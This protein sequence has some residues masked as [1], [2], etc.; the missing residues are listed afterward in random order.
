MYLA[1]RSKKTFPTY[2]QAF[3][4][5]WCHGIEIGKMVFWWTDMEFA[6]HLILLN[7]CNATENMFKQAS[8]VVSLLKEA[9]EL[10]SL[11]GSKVV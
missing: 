8:A 6:G 9:V 4:K 2:N 11:A 7:E 1:G 3:R 5:L 10:E